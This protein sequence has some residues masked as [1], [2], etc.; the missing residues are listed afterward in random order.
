VLNRFAFELNNPIGYVDPT[1][2][3]STGLSVFF[4][5]VIGIAAVVLGIGLIA[6][7]GGAAAP[8]VLGALGAVLGTV[9]GGALL[10]GGVT[11]TAYSLSHTSDFDWT[12][13][14]IELGISAA[15]GAVTGGLL[16]GANTAIAAGVA[17]ITSELGQ[18][19]FR[20]GLSSLAAGGLG[21]V[22]DLLGQLAVNAA[23]DDALEKGLLTAAIAGGLAGL[24]AGSVGTRVGRFAEAQFKKVPKKIAFIGSIRRRLD[25]TRSNKIELANPLDYRLLV[26]PALQRM[27]RK[28]QKQLV[29][30]SVAFGGVS[31][32][33]EA[34]ADLPEQFLKAYVDDVL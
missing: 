14:G 18:T 3:I 33:I 13:F 25:I 17:R 19:A 20:Y 15:V 26:N 6:V 4:G 8:G 27:E 29:R 7:T 24:L 5:I 2:H 11:A 31:N 12:N 10:S 22:G 30:L 28:L 16:Y 9:I 21:A 1:G 23:E 34:F 32:A